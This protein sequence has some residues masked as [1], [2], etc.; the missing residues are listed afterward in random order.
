MKLK[1]REGGKAAQGHTASYWS[2]LRLQ[3]PQQSGPSLSSWPELPALT[4][5]EPLFSVPTPQVPQA[6]CCVTWERE[7]NVYCQPAANQL[8]PPSTCS[9]PL[10]CSHEDSCPLA[11]PS[12]NQPGCLHP[13]CQAPNQCL[14]V[15]TSAGRESWNLPPHSDVDT[16]S[17]KTR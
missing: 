15:M 4:L 2:Q 16:C 14:V 6:H 3:A 9:D 13:I 5:P 1:H 17:R 10:P 12:P 11:T 7:V 8:P